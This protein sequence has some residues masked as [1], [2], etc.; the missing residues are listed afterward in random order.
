MSRGLGHIRGLNVFS[1]KAYGSKALQL[2]MHAPATWLVR[3]NWAQ[4]A[5][6]FG[7]VRRI[8]WVRS[9]GPHNVSRRQTGCRI[10]TSKKRQ[11][12]PGTR[13]RNSISLVSL[14][15]NV[16]LGYVKM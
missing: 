5:I 10:R 1:T 9:Y 15:F 6:G 7:C 8:D 4:L 3:C 2:A 12:T 16:I 13:V 11:D 14:L